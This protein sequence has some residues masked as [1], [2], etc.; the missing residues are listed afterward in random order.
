MLWN[1][2]D[3]DL[4]FGISQTFIGNVGKTAEWKSLLASESMQDKDTHWQGGF[5]IHP[6][7][8]LGCWFVADLFW[9]FVGN[10][11]RGFPIYPVELL[12]CWFVADLLIFRWHKMKTQTGKEAF[13]FTQWNRWNFE[14]T[15]CILQ[16]DHKKTS[17]PFPHILCSSETAQLLWPPR[18]EE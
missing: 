3:V 1:C 7:E 4:S 13:P 8:S 2:F 18:C 10:V 14:V 15:T 12:G 16:V 17:N 6:V 5:S 11:C 9:S